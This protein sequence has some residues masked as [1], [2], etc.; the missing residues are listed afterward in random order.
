MRSQGGRGGGGL[1]KELSS[2][3]YLILAQ[4]IIIIRIIDIFF[5]Y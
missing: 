4:F 3:D 5:L 1:Y 2:P